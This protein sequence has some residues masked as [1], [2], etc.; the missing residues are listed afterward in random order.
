[1][2]RNSLIMGEERQAVNKQTAAFYCQHTARSWVPGKEGVSVVA[3]MFAFKHS[4][5]FYSH[6]QNSEST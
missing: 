1:M 2:I 4:T 5:L 3:A 6:L